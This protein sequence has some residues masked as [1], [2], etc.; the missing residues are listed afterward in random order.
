MSYSSS[1][2]T[3]PLLHRTIANLLILLEKNFGHSR[4]HLTSWFLREKFSQPF[5]TLTAESSGQ[6]FLKS[7]PKTSLVS[8][9][10]QWQIPIV[11]QSSDSDS[12][13]DSSSDLV[14]LYSVVKAYSDYSSN[15]HSDSLYSVVV[16][17]LRILKARVLD[18][19]VLWGAAPLVYAHGD[20]HLRVV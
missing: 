16:R 9:S 8:Q 20:H 13:S 17:G 6:K 11:K 15:N 4:G 1:G 5:Q 7:N 14:T 18:S 2:N 19:V 3:T 12:D 10:K